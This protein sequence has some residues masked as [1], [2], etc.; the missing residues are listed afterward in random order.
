PISGAQDVPQSLYPPC[1]RPL[2][3]GTGRPF[4]R[5]T[6]D[7]A[8]AC[9]RQGTDRAGPASLQEADRTQRHAERTPRTPALREAQRTPPPRPP[10]QGKSRPQGPAQHLTRAPPGTAAT[11]ETQA[12]DHGASHPAPSSPAAAR[13]RGVV[14]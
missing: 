11:R 7:L 5:R 3:S 13:G 10:A 9:P 4:G 8:N 6:N 14:S 1:L 2:G 12:G